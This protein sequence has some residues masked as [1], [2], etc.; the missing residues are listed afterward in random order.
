MEIT[1]NWLSI[2]VFILLSLEGWCNFLQETCIDFEGF[3]KLKGD[4]LK[5][6]SGFNFGGDSKR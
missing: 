4:M 1:F 5:N 3:L 2:F 6:A